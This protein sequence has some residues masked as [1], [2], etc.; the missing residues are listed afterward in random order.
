MTTPIP[1]ASERNLNDPATDTL[2]HRDKISLL[3]LFLPV[4]TSCKLQVN[5][6]GCYWLLATARTERR[7]VQY[8]SKPISSIC[9]AIDRL[10][11]RRE[12]YIHVQ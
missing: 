6:G 2:G 4:T 8:G 7:R 9:C 5:P 1:P 3:V 12:M 11:G 10:R